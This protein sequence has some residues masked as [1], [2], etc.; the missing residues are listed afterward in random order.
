MHVKALHIPARLL[1]AG[2]AGFNGL[3]SLSPA[4][5]PSTQKTGSRWDQTCPDNLK[6]IRREERNQKRLSGNYELLAY[7]N[8][9][10]ER[11]CPGRQIHVRSQPTG[12]KILG[13][14][15]ESNLQPTA[16]NTNSLQGIAQTQSGL[17]GVRDSFCANWRRLIGQACLGLRL[18]RQLHDIPEFLKIQSHQLFDAAHWCQ[19]YSTRA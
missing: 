16:V 11:S 7:P 3:W 13:E 5:L 8:H 17:T 6:V 4:I 19:P 15:H 14:V 9:I 10:A 2:W 18:Y 12:H 1:T